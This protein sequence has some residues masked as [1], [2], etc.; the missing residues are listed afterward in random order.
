M[1]T[2]DHFQQLKQHI[3]L[4]AEENRIG[5]CLACTYWDADDVKR[6]ESQVARVAVCLHPALV[7]FSLLVSG[8]SACGKWEEEPAAGEAAKT[9]SQRYQP[10]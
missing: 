5:A 9:Y 10:S 8:G 4:V 2:F 3:P 7:E 6:D 1:P